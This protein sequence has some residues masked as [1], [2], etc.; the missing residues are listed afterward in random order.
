MTSHFTSA[1]VISCDL[2]RLTIAEAEI[3]MTVTSQFDSNLDTTNQPIN[4][5]ALM[6][7]W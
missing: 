2:M 4:D 7:M 5:I 6:K 3:A 1:L